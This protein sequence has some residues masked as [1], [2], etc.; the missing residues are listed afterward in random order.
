MPDIGIYRINMDKE[1]ELNDLYSF[2]HAFA[3]TY[4]FAYCFDSDLSPRDADRINYALENY[5]WRGGYS[6][7]N[8]YTVL[9]NQVPPKLR[10]RIKQIQ[11]A[12]PGWMD[13]ALNLDPAIK[14]AAAVA[15]I[16][17]S[18]V[19][20]TKA[21]ASIQ[22]TLQDIKL[23]REK[24]KVAHLQ[25][26]KAQAKELRGLCEELSKL[27]GFKKFEELVS[28]TGDIEIAAKLLAAQFRRLKAIAEF[29]SKGKIGLPLS[30]KNKRDG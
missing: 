6:Y 22:K 5:P 30:S 3:Q 28:R 15:S 8:I 19:A 26:S 17:G 12:S 11:Y 24:S 23:Q 21:Y 9:Q 27:V 20:T 14:V 16:A 4:A 7:V 18:M 1:W 13:L 10:P 25:L 2:P 29:S